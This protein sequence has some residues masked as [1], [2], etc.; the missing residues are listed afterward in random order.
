MLAHLAQLEKESWTAQTH[1]RNFATE[2]VLD[3]ALLD[4]VGG[5]LLDDGEELL[6]THL[7]E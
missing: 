5:L 3:L 7:D 4:G 2:L 1:N 6:D